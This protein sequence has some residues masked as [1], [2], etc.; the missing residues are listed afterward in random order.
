MNR[1][2]LDAPQ[3]KRILNIL[4]VLLL[5]SFAIFLVFN[6]RAQVSRDN[7]YQISFDP[8]NNTYTVSPKTSLSQQDLT[9]INNELKK[10]SGSDDLSK[11]NV[12][13]DP[14]G[15]IIGKPKDT[16]DYF[17]KDAESLKA[18]D[19]VIKQKLLDIQPPDDIGD[20]EPTTT[21]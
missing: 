17:N 15:V 2:N 13:F 9:D 16:V 12:D 20:T 10:I 14:A 5:I 7:K 19:D 21:P 1:L 18:N 3:F 8:A 4:G 11:L 6:N